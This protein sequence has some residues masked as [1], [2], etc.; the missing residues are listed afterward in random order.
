MK[1]LA[2]ISLLVLLVASVQGYTTERQYQREF[3]KFVK[4]YNKRYTSDDFFNRFAIFKENIDLIAEFNSQ[5]GQTASLG[6]NAFSDMTSEEMAAKMNGYRPQ[7][8]KAKKVRAIEL[9]APIKAALDW[10]EQGAV[11]AVKDQGQCGSCWS[12]SAT[13]AIEGAV[14]LKLGN[15]TSLSEQQLMDC[16][17]P[18]GDDSCEGGMMDSAFQFVLDNKGIC[19]E[20]DYPYKAVDEKCKKTCTI[21]ST[22][23]DFADV[24]SNA[25]NITDETALM[26]AVQLGPVSIAIQADQPIFQM[27]KDGVISSPSCGGRTADDLDHGVLL[28]G[29]DYDNSTG[30]DYWLVKNSWGAAWGQK[31]Y[32]KLARGQNECGLNWMASYPIA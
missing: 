29:Y 21:V 22:I 5:P 11:T 19:A 31:G 10:K 23:T 13:G 20:D 9:S 32:V 18:E 25:K 4:N 30:L 26:A 3:S 27:Y 7:P 8:N 12:F 2:V 15:L 16:S 6:V 1:V 17:H 24:A 14:Y 28:V